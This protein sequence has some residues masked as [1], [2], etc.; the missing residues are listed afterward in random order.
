MAGHAH[1]VHESEKC[2]VCGGRRT[3]PP[4]RDCRRCRFTDASGQRHRP[5]CRKCGCFVPEVWAMS[6]DLQSANNPW[7]MQL[8]IRC[9]GIFRSIQDDVVDET[10]RA[11]LWNARRRR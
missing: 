5:R 1:P 4:A 10:E 9:D 3:D 7:P 2:V 11:R 6:W 8:C